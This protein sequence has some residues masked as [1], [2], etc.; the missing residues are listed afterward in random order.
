MSP[1]NM[2]FSHQ[3]EIALELSKYFEETHVI[4]SD[5]QFD[6]SPDNVSV[7]STN[8]SEGKIIIN[9]LRFYVCAIPVLIKNRKNS[10]VFFHMVDVQAF[11]LAGICKLLGIKNYL[12]YAHK[13][14]SVYLNLAAP[15]LT[16]I[17]TS[18]PGSCPIKGKRVTPIGQAVKIPSIVDLVP[19]LREEPISWYHIGRLDPSK[20]IDEIILALKELRKIHPAIKLSIYGKASSNVTEEYASGLIKNYSTGEFRNW[21]TFHGELEHSLLESVS[22]QHDGFI[23]AYQGSLD[24]TLVEAAMLKRI[25]VS[26]NPEFSVEF[27]GQEQV[28]NVDVGTLLRYKLEML[29][30]TSVATRLECINH[31]FELAVRE[32][33]MDVWLKR[34]VSELMEVQQ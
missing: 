14:S 11:L 4:T 28:A 18:T 1:S 23:H 5:G 25:I 16:R 17:F 10:V 26:A 12:W 20:N 31:N 13:A 8:W 6:S 7:S 15:F 30:K 34:L 24:K 27:E 32:H 22:L 19:S 29:Y 2:L 3:R 33:S 21:I 9:V